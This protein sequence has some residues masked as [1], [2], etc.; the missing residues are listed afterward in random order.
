MIQN[1]LDKITLEDIEELIENSIP[2]GKS[3]DY[4]EKFN[5]G[6]DNDKKEFLFDVSSFANASG[7]DIIIGV[8]EDKSTGYPK[9][10]QGIK[11]ENKDKLQLHL[12]SIIRDSISPRL[13]SV[14]Y[15]FVAVKEDYYVLIIR[16]SKSWN[17]PHQVIFKGTD[18]FYSRSSNGK[19]KLDVFEL[20]NA[21]IASV[22]MKQNIIKFRNSR[23]SEIISN[24]GAVPLLDNGKIILHVV[25]FI[26][27]E[28]GTLIDLV[29][30]NNK[31]DLLRPIGD[32]GF[33]TRFNFD[34][35]LSYI[36]PRI[37]EPND[38][39]LQLFKNGIIETVDSWVIQPFREEKKLY[40]ESIEEFIINF[41]YRV[42][43]L[44]SIAKIDPPIVLLLTM[45]G[46]YDYELGLH[47][48]FIF[49]TK[50]NVGK[51]ILT[52]PD[53]MI[54]NWDNIDMK[55]K[56]WFDALWNSVG[57]EG[58]KSYKDGKWIRRKRN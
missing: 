49:L 15:H 58:S 45:T 46:A 35:I 7:G 16:I 30:I 20:R 10:I 50:K 8:T 1:E 26:S 54:E 21:F 42:P 24:E 2:E 22:S 38:S 34:G 13:P 4:K 27:F 52:F 6:K 40:I 32:Q 11:I 12:D 56:P 57:M 17:K 28:T 43:K 53:I 19:Y 29:E 9:E 48:S 47:N 44:Y 25:P 23:L 31:R 5:L 14:N 36:N 39:Y 18:K 41:I 3:I 55:I 33:S 51:D 37:N